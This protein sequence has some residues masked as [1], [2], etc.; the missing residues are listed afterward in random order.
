[1]EEMEELV[2]EYEDWKQKE[3]LIS[4]GEDQKR[5][6]QSDREEREI[7]D[8]CKSRGMIVEGNG[9]SFHAEYKG[10]TINFCNQRTRL[11]G[12]Y[13]K[14]IGEKAKDVANF[15]NMKSDRRLLPDKIRLMFDK[16]FS[17]CRLCINGEPTQVM[18]II[19]RLID[20]EE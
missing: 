20:N 5:K 4:S 17:Y 9:Y 18:G 16:E 3:N 15:H 7:R 11:V 2:R 14:I 13:H 1:M 12:S 10:F 6:E 8:Y 19:L